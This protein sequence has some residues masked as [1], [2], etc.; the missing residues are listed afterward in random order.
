MKG[1]IFNILSEA[2][3]QAFGE[4]EWD[5]VLDAAGVDGAYTSLGN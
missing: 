2:V 1:I 3:V 5:D 4:D